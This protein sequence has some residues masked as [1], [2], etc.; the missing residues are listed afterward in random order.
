MHMADALLSP[1]VGGVFLAA[2]GAGLAWSAKKLRDGGD[3]SKIPLMGVLGA[4][5]FA[6]QMI[7]FT[8]PGTGSSGHIGGGMLVTMLVGPPAAFVVMASVL[9]V[10]SLLFADGGVLAL[11][12]NIWN[13]GF[14]PC[15]LGWAIYKLIAGKA[16]TPLRLSAAAVA[17]AVISLEAGAFSVVL[18]TLASGRSE[19]PFGK[20][21]A[22]MLG[23]HFPI[24]LI[25]GAMTVAVV[26]FVYRMR[27]EV[28]K[29]NL[30]LGEG[31]LDVR[32]LR[33]VLAAF[34]A[35]AMFTGILLAWFASA[36]PDG[37][38]WSIGKVTGSEEL[39]APK[40]GLLASLAG[41]QEKT[42]LL[43]DYGFKDAGASEGA[44]EEAESWP[45]VSGGTSVSG[46]V[47]A[48]IVLIFAAGTSLVLYKLRGKNPGET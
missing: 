45:A 4:F 23:I 36:H 16:P 7:N 34:V 48:M 37:L 12:T 1:A 27:P 39:E 11:G 47:G 41:L 32:S 35:A 28:I 33:P 2:S 24:G 8:I 9:I 3:E 31:S 17:G 5:V 21:T 42:A 40:E 25:E 29:N 15:V 22:L 38:E 18:E 46:L 14:Y 6:G 13:M 20:F 44:G 30:G 43:P 26:N 10:Q 19:L